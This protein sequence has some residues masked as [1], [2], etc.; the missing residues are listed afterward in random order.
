MCMAIIGLSACV[1]S[2]TSGVDGMGE[3]Q[4]TIEDR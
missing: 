4:N 2:W 3:H 1:H